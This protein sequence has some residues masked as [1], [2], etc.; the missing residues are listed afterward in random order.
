MQKKIKN[1]QEKN[2]RKKK[3]KNQ[4]QEIKIIQ[5]IKISQEIKTKIFK[6]THNKGEKKRKK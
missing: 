3:E 2:T 6:I 5:E 4:P 1:P